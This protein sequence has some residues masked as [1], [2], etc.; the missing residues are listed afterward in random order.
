MGHCMGVGMVEGGRC[1]YVYIKPVFMGWVKI[2]E[3]SVVSAYSSC[4]QLFILY[5]KIYRFE[6]LFSC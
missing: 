1:D 6:R 3:F 5:I 2:S 4:I